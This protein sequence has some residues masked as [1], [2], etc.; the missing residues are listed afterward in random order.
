MIQRLSKDQQ[1][2]VLE[3]NKRPIQE[4]VHP[5]NTDFYENCFKVTSLKCPMSKQVPRWTEKTRIPTE[6]FVCIFFVCLGF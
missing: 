6:G 3:I 5:K 1:S 2:Y 4:T